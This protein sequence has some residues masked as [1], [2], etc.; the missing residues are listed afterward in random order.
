VEAPAE[1]HEWLDL[2]DGAGSDAAVVLDEQFTVV[3]RGG[4]NATLTGISDLTELTDTSS[5]L[6]PGSLAPFV[7]A[8]AE[9]RRRPGHAVPV[10]FAFRAP[11]GELAVHGWITDIGHRLP[12]HTLLRFCLLDQPPGGATPAGSAPPGT[13]RPLDPEDHEPLHL[14]AEMSTLGLAVALPGGHLVYRNQAFGTWFPGDRVDGLRDL[15][16]VVREDAAQEVAMWADAVTDGLTASVTAPVESDGRVR[17]LRFDG[18][19]RGSQHL[20]R[21][22]GV[23]VQD[24]TEVVATRESM[25]QVLDLLP[26][27]VFSVDAG[28]ALSFAN[29]AT[30]RFLGI[31]GGSLE[32]VHLASALGETAGAD[33]LAA[34][35]ELTRSGRTV[36]DLDDVVA[37]RDGREHHLRT[38]LVPYNDATSGTPTV[39]AVA[40]DVTRQVANEALLTALGRNMPDLAVISHGPDD[41]SFASASVQHL[42]GW[43]PEEFLS[44]PVN[45]TVHPADLERASVL[46]DPQRSDPGTSRT[47]EVRLLHRDGSWRWFELHAVNLA[48]VP[49][50]DGMLMFGRDIM[51]R[52]ARDQQLHFEATHDPLTALLNRSAIIEQLEL[53]LGETRELGDPVGAL[54]IDLD[55]FKLVNDALGHETGDSLLQ[56]VASALESSLRA[57][58]TVGRLGGDEFLVIVRDVEDEDTV[59]RVARRV[60]DSVASLTRDTSYPVTLSIGACVSYEGDTT[61]G[62]MVRDADAAMY[63]AKVA[64]KARTQLFHSAIGQHAERRLEVSQEL[65]AALDDDRF[66][67]HFQPVFSRQDD[68][69]WRVRAL[70]ALARCPLHDGSMLRPDE[71]VPV[72]EQTGL[73]VRMGRRVVSLALQALRRWHHLGYPVQVWINLSMSELSQPE[74]AEHLLAGLRRSGLPARSLGV[75]VTESMLGEVPGAH[76]SLLQRLRAAGITVLIDDFGTGYSSLGALKETPIDIAKIDRSFTA[77]ML[78]SAPDTAIVQSVINIG[79]VMGFEVVAEGVETSRQLQALEDLE[80]HNVQGW[81]FTRALPADEVAA[82]LPAWTRG[83]TDEEI[84]HLEVGPAPHGH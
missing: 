62:A 41:R 55:N 58:D 69:M 78:D 17:W 21:L 27:M 2:L 22:H 28:G 25:R 30:R 9:S 75:E 16:D 43:T 70:E 80:C 51:A 71:F 54:F 24:V 76:D 49:A 37:D 82:Q 1:H 31:G 3:W 42:L 29:D 13:L 5:M 63:R 72:A 35:E 15:S 12:G 20:G 48:N 77:G 59:L 18:A 56:D 34:V 44:L 14:M 64:G 47:V 61:A 74:L 46:H 53:A 66:T 11:R 52:K 19:E 4:S 36:T 83:Y 57:G 38:W 65:A 32:G 45:D 10:E 8:L 81:L 73:V 26:V 39:L 68:G 7:E 33:L 60:S 6:E 84:R 50:I 67:V 79:S 23:T 40:S